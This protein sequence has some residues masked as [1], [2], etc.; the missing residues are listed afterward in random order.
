[1]SSML[2]VHSLMRWVALILLVVATAQAW[3]GWLGQQRWS[4]AQRRL[5][6]LA[7]IS[8]DVQLLLGLLVFA[9]SD[10]VKAALGDMGAAMRSPVLRFFTVEHTVM[11]VAAIALV[12][13]GFARSK[14]LSDDAARFR[15]QALFFG[16][17][18]VVALA[19]IPWP[20]R[21]AVARALLP[22]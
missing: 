3:R 22:F 7:M 8:F 2:V 15:A 21:T 16:A 11:M 18:L 9:T 5:G 13:I 1:M 20:F 17:A 4:D 6:L 12:H 14:R 19:A 10:L